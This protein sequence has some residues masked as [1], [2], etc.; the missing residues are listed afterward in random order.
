MRRSSTIGSD[1]SGGVRLRIERLR[2]GRVWLRIER[3]RVSTSEEEEEG[4]DDEIE[5][6][7]EHCGG[8]R[9]SEDVWMMR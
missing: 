4:A 3:G 6:E 5:I 7:L 9:R 2:A 8:V 1:T